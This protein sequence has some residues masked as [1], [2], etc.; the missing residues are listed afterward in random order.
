MT[1]SA[2][3]NKYDYRTRYTVSTGPLID[4]IHYYIMRFACD[5]F[6]TDC[7]RRLARVLMGFK[8]S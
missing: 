7:F 5:F 4:L 8:S 3:V 2:S 1:M 6:T